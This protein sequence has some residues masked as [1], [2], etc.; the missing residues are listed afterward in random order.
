VHTVCASSTCYYDVWNI[1]LE[2][3]RTRFHGSTIFHSQASP[4]P[5]ARPAARIGRAVQP[6]AQHGGRMPLRKHSKAHQEVPLLKIMWPGI[7]F[8]GNKATPR[9]AGSDRAW[10]GLRDRPMNPRPDH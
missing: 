2:R 6:G 5:A 10:A 8:I 4:R 1:D 7:W 9:F 3:V